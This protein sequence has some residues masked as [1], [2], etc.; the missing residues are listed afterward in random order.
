MKYEMFFYQFGMDILT[1]RIYFDQLKL[2]S[3]EEFEKDIFQDDCS[4][5]NSIL[6]EVIYF[7]K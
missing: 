1:T 5:M 6:D 4:L 7:G 2:W 3:R